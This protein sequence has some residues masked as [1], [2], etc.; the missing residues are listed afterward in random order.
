MGAATDNERLAQAIHN[1]GRL[2]LGPTATTGSFPYGGVNLGPHRDAE[3]VW[4]AQYFEVRD[5][6]SGRVV[7]MGRDG[8]EYPE[9]YCLADGIWDEDIV[10]GA[11]SRYTRASSTT[12]PSPAEA[13]IDGANVPKLVAAW[14]PLLFVAD[15]P[16]H[17]SVY[18]RR[19]LPTLSLRQ[20]SALSR[21]AKV[22]L[23]LRFIPTPDLA[24]ASTPDWQIA[25]L[26][27]ITL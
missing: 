20:A 11:F 18:F 12:Y 19:P 14:P 27:N 17:K 5:P 26:E 21:E 7:E 25:R 24:W 15:D 9:I 6:A 10:V 23:P 1:P 4:Q 16:M 22:G 8:A 3:I 2:V 13:R